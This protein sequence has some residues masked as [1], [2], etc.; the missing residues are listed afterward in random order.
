M[1]RRN[2]R[3]VAVLVSVM[4]LVIFSGWQWVRAGHTPSHE[5]LIVWFFDVGQ[6]DA[7]FIES[8]TGEQ[9]LI[10]G[11]PGS[12]V[13]EK[14]EAVMPFWDRS[15]DAVLL[16]HPHADHVDGLV[17]VV[18]RYEVE[19][20]YW[21][22]VEYAT[23]TADAFDR[24]I[25]D[26][27]EVL[28]TGPRTIDLG[29]G[30]TLEIIFPTESFKDER[31]S[32]VNGSSIVAVLRYGATSVLLTGDLTETE[33][34]LLLDFVDAS[35]DVLKVGHHGSGYSSTRA[36]LEDVKPEIAVISVG[37]ENDYGHPHPATLERLNDAGASILRTDLHGDIRLISEGGEPVLSAIPL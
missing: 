35:V 34:P 28:V 26:E 30:A 13:L 4:L 31:V 36:F 20:V 11:G 22:G 9:M 27:V 8:P 25:D 19:T 23:T 3:R 12:T 24:R 7:I 17:E 1:K 18:D 14:L 37:A 21:T 2:E 16:T 29:G 32:D 6:G 10:D 15:L 33:E 5:R